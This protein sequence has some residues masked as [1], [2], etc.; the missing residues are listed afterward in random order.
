MVKSTIFKVYKMIILV[1][2][3]WFSLSVL[4]FYKQK[5]NKNKRNIILHYEDM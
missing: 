2:E 4:N 1:I 3:F 5:I